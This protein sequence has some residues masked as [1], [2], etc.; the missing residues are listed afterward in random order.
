MT[1]YCLKII[2][3]TLFIFLIFSTISCN[4]FNRGLGFDYIKDDNDKT[5]CALEKKENDKS[6]TDNLKTDNKN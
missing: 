2:K 3:Y 6:K 1:N 5:S 4:Y